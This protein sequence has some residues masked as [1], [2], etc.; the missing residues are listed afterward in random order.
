M[1]RKICRE[2][3]FRLLYQVEFSEKEEYPELV[4]QLHEFIPYDDAEN[5][6]GDNDI[7]Q[8][9][10]N[11]ELDKEEEDYVSRKFEDITNHLDEIDASLNAKTVD[12]TTDRMGKVELAILRLAYYEMKYDDDIPESVA[13]NEAVELSK[14]YIP[15]EA[16]T[17]VNGVLGKCAEDLAGHKEAAEKKTKDRPWK[18]KA[19]AQVVVKGSAKKKE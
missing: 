19:K 17:F 11:V 15:G 13:I 14:K 7:I 8:K 16:Y 3:I 18:E 2:Q 6:D 1:R 10:L 12:W 5:K 4:K 9:A